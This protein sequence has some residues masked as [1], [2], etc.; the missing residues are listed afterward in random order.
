MPDVLD[1]A[2]ANASHRVLCETLYRLTEQIHEAEHPIVAQGRLAF[3]KTD[4][5]DGLR[6]MRQLVED[7]IVRRCNA[8]ADR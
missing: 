5:L 4:R 7:E 8:Q 3:V 2:F 1:E 6:Q